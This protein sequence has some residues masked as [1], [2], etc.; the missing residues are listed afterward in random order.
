MSLFSKKIHQ[1]I[2]YFGLLLLAV[3]LPL[4]KFGM[5]IGMLALSANWLLEGNLKY[6][7][8][9]FFKNKPA[10]VFSS[11]FVMHIVWLLNT[12]NFDYGFND[13]RTK[14]PIFALAVV[15]STT[16]LISIK[17]F[18]TVLYAHIGAVLAAT[19]VGIYIYSTQNITEIRHISPFI[20]HIRLSLNICIAVFSIF[21]FL[22]YE[23]SQI[24]AYKLIYILIIFW[25]IQ[26]LFI[27]QSMTGVL[28]ILIVSLFLLL[29][30]IINAKKNTILRLSLI[31]VFIIVPITLAFFLHQLVNTYFTPKSEQTQQLDDT[32][33]LGS[34]YIH[35]TVFMPVENGTWT[36]LYMCL[37]ELQMAWEEKSKIPFYQKDSDGQDI[38]ITLIR[39]LN[40][41]GLRKDYQGVSQLSDKDIENVEKG[42]AN[43]NYTKFISIKTRLYKIFWEYQNYRMNGDIQG[44]SV[45]QRI[46]LWHTSINL[47]K[48]HFWF[49]VGT[50]DLPDVF[51]EELIAQNS[52]LKDTRMRSHN[53]FLSI[54]VAF[55]VFGFL[56]FI[57]SLL[58]PV[59]KTK[60]Y[61]DFYFMVFLIV[62][63]LSM[64]TEDTIEPQDGL[65]FFAYFYSLFLFQR[66]P[67]EKP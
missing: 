57:F 48:K 5:S 61:K 38:R 39:Y 14:I 45:I 49:G 58:Y 67:N 22:L 8:S 52:P 2:F 51:K 25:L 42:I 43:F 55:G 31:S 63:L 19:F 34:Y 12:S 1:N 36:G 13:L 7:F 30:F 50:G 18:K 59:I 35:D 17:Q 6:K 40:S 21:Y 29:Y 33:A 66:P 4:S 3:S 15:L 24:F 28:I 54:F 27:L 11:I 56:W 47:I 46:E 60:K 41:K 16:S 37:P 23:R 65:S 32:T 62:L 9:L 44:H 10:L 64:L 20:S 53:Q 26:F